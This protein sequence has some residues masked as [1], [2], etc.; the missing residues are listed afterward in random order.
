VYAFGVQVRRQTCTGK[1]P[2]PDESKI[3]AVVSMWEGRRPARL[4]HSQLSD[5]L[6]GVIE[7]CWRV[8]PGQRITIHEVVAALE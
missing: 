8:E 3:A 6:W 1:V 7:A 2:F 4:V 5:K